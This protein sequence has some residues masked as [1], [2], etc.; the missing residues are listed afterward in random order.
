MKVKMKINGK[1]S[2]G[3]IPISALD[4]WKDLIVE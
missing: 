2:E 1:V 4:T 3:T